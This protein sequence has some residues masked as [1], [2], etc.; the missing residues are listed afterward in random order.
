MY[1]MSPLSGALRGMGEF[2]RAFFPHM[3]FENV[4][5]DIEDLGKNYA[6][7]A[8]MPGF[9]KNDISIDLKGNIM[10]ISAARKKESADE[11]GGYIRRERTCGKLTRSFNISNVRKDAV[12]ASYRDGVL[13]IILPKKDENEKATNI[14]IE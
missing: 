3:D 5:C 11:R 12:T 14:F 2:E 13:R 1:E 10:T 9:D 4:R 8:D 7:T 6:I